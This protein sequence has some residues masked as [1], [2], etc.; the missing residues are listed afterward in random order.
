MWSTTHQKRDNWTTKKIHYPDTAAV[1]ESFM[2]Y[3]PCD[4]WEQ[5]SVNETAFLW[6]T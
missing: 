1:I 3:R 6:C 4:T 2:T 5:T